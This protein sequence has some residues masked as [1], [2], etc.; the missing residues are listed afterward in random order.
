VQAD[1]STTPTTSTVGADLSAFP[2]VLAARITDLNAC[3]SRL[4]GT[5]GTFP[6]Q[7]IQA[8]SA[9]TPLLYAYYNLDMTGINSPFTQ[10]LT[11]VTDQC[12]LPANSAIGTVRAVLEPKPD[13]IVDANDPRSLV[14]I[15]T[16]VCGLIVINNES[17]WYEGWI[18]HDMHVPQ[19]G[20]A[21]ADL[22]APFGMITQADAD[23]LKAMG[24]GN[25]LPGSLFTLDGLAAHGAAVGDEL[26]SGRITNTVSVQV[27]LGS[28][29]ALQGEDA[30]AYWELNEYT[31]W[32]FPV[33][34]T[35]GTGGVTADF[36]KGFQY[37]PLGGFGA[38]V[39]SRVPGSGP[40]GIL[41]NISIDGKLHFGDD[42]MHPRDPDRTPESCGDTATQAEGRLRFIPSGLAREIQVDVLMRRASFEPDVT[43]LERRVVDA[44]AFEVAK[45]DRN[46]DGVVQFGEADID[47][48]LNG[49]PNTRLYLAPS[50]F[51]R[52]TITREINDGLL[53]PRLAP[54]AQAQVLA[55]SVT[56]IEKA[57]EKDAG[58]MKHACDNPTT[59]HKLTQ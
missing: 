58:G 14:D 50:E 23:M 9:A 54:T 52:V 6:V 16:D 55:G 28:W 13:A 20:A 48:N 40:V 38:N 32:V 34:E 56:L 15:F 8:E 27:S 3:Q 51:N 26:M 41:N 43:D 59:D 5:H 25:N 49:V 46:N 1:E 45:I 47:D 36:R 17:G 30:H 2:P 42:P 7:S 11:G 37:S 10:Q 19:I 24:E 21:G 22:H 53:A 31:N 57:E 12:S 39:D 44:Y 4:Q 29:N 18:A 33:Y 35:L